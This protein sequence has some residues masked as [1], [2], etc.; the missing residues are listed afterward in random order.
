MLVMADTNGWHD[1]HHWIIF[2]LFWLIVIAIAIVL[3]RRGGWGPRRSAR[4]IL[5]E[6]FARGE[7]SAEEYRERRGQLS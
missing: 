2:P 3:F 7:I 1:G 4:T 6:R 5:A